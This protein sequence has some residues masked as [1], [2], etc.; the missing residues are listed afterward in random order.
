VFA[1]LN[2]TLNPYLLLASR[3]PEITGM[4]LVAQRT[5]LPARD[6]CSN[7]GGSPWFSTTPGCQLVNAVRCA[8]SA[9]PCW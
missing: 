4:A 8:T 3:Q 2:I 6:C 7:G 5:A 1:T 9:S